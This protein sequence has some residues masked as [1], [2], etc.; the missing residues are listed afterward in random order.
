MNTRNSNVYS[1]IREYKYV[2]S[3]VSRFLAANMHVIRVT[4]IKEK[5]LFIDVGTENVPLYVAHV[6]NIYGHGVCN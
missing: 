3:P 2:D 4:D 1:I 5:V 6:P